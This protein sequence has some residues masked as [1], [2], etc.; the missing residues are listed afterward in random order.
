[1]TERERLP[2]RR[3]A[4]TFDLRWAVEANE[5]PD[6]SVT[7]GY[8]LDGRPGEVFAAGPKDG[9]DMQAIINDA[10]V[11]LSIALQHGAA[12][13]ALAHS[14][15]R[16]PVSKTEDRPSSVIGA[17]VDKLVSAANPRESQA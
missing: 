15:G 14:M 7:V 16:T 5:K 1:M 11:I 8:Y 10:C 6:Y 13:A 9:S 12:P 17:V 2:T 4:E 3:P